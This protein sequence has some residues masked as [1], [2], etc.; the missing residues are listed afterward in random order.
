[1]TF[2]GAHELLIAWLRDLGELGIQVSA[3]AKSAVT[4]PQDISFRYLSR[5]LEGPHT[6]DSTTTVFWDYTRELLMTSRDGQSEVLRWCRICARSG[7]SVPPDVLRSLR[8][9]LCEDDQNFS[10]TSK[11]LDYL[12][13]LGLSHAGRTRTETLD[14]ALPIISR[15]VRHFEIDELNEIG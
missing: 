15:S 7:V 4:D 9:V 1:M 11:L 14:L 5:L 2:S 3:T 10:L 8:D 6:I 13:A 12:T